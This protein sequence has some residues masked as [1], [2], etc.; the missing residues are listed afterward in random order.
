MEGNETMQYT[1]VEA[2]WDAYL[3]SCPDGTPVGHARSAYL[4]G[5]RAGFEEA[6]R[7]DMED[8]RDAEAE[9]A[10]LDRELA[11]ARR[12]LRRFA[13]FVGAGI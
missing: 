3:R 13:T 2:G 5:Y 4:A 12:D 6:Y 9:T 10:R 7:C 8:L 11:E 1:E